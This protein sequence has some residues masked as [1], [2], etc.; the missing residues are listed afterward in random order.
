[1]T[2]ARSSFTAP[3]PTPVQSPWSDAL[4]KLNYNHSFVHNYEDKVCKIKMNYRAQLDQ[5][6]DESRPNP[7]GAI[8]IIDFAHAFFNEEDERGIDYN[9]KEGIDNFV[10]IFEAFLKETDNQV[11]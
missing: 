1:M 10:A 8:K 6:S 5:L 3:S 7:W 2:L 4:E 11:Y 9:F